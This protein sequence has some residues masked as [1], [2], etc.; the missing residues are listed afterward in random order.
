M[1]KKRRKEIKLRQTTARS[2]KAIKRCKEMSKCAAEIEGWW[3]SDGRGLH[4]TVCRAQL[5][6]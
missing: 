5:L 3:G 2:G 4:C 6:M 1:I